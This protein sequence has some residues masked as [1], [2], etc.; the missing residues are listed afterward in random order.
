MWGL[1]PHSTVRGCD[2]NGG[3]LLGASVGLKGQ[4]TRPLTVA[5]RTQPG[6]NE[7]AKVTM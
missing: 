2:A 5:E 4:T 1:V 6:L 7:E 3:G